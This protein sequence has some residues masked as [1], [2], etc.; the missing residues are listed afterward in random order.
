MMSTL[1]EKH[2]QQGHKQTDMKLFTEKLFI[3]A[4]DAV[5]TETVLK[6]RRL[7]EWKE[8]TVIN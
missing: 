3:T 6:Y 8:C 2:L 1:I 5:S 7:A 4:K